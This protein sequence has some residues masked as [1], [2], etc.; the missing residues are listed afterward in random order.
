M[1][2]ARFTQ[3][4]LNLAH[5]AR[6]LRV[7]QQTFHRWARGYERGG[8][9]LHVVGNDRDTLPVTFIALAEAH[10]LEA[11]RTAGV[12]PR[13]IRPALNELQREFGQ[14]YVLVAPELAT[15]GIDVLWDF[16]RSRAGEGLIVGNTG[17]HVIKEIVA[18]HMQYIA[19]GSDGLPR[20]LT[21]ANWQPSKVIVD[22]RRSFGQPILAATGTRVADIA[23]MM[24]AG[25]SAETVADEFGIDISAARAAARILLGRAA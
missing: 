5:A 21:L 25:E 7:P 10:V 14:E 4:I 15:D 18:E 20:Q 17:Q 2:D 1:N 24:K 9:L 3:G 22:V 13:K 23:G 6:H 19:F 16:S 11:L 12:Q 8:P